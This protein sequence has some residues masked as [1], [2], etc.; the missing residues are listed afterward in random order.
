MRRLAGR[1]RGLIR[2]LQKHGG[3][4]REEAPPVGVSRGVTGIGTLRGGGEVLWSGGGVG[5]QGP[6]WLGK[7]EPAGGEIGF[8]FFQMESRAF[9]VYQKKLTFWPVLTNGICLTVNVS[10]ILAWKN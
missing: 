9:S 3:E 2:K 1:P 10:G 4:Q 5:Y 6:P 8:L 7:R